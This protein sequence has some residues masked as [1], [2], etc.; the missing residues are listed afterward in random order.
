M[1]EPANPVRATKLSARSGWQTAWM[2]PFAA[3]A[4]YCTFK[5]PF[6]F[7]PRDRLYSASYAFGFNNSVA[8][9]SF[10]ILLGVASLLFARRVAAPVGNFQ[11]EKTICRPLRVAFVFMSVLYLLATAAMYRYQITSAPWLMWE[12]RHLSYRTLLMDVYHLHAYTD[13]SAEY[14]PLLTYAPFYLYQL[15]KPFRGTNEQAY[16]ICHLLL[17]LGGLG[18][19]VYLLSYVKLSSLSRIVIFVSLAISGFAPYMGINGV[20]LRY[21]LP[22]ASLLIAWRTTRWSIDSSPEKR[23]WVAVGAIIFL[24][25]SANL[26]ISS[27]I[28]LAFT[29]AWLSY[30]VFTF[31]IT[32][33]L[34]MVSLL[35]AALV[36]LACFFFLPAAYYLTLL[37]FSR[38]ANNFPLLP[39]PHLLLYLGTMFVIVP[40]LLGNVLRK[41]W[42]NSRS[43]ALGAALAVLCMAMAPGALGRCDPPHVLLYGMGATLLLMI[44]L[45]ATRPAALG[46]YAAGYFAVFVVWMQLVHL[47]VFYQIPPDA[48]LSKKGITDIFWKL[49]HS[50]ATEAPDEKV[51]SELDRYSHIGLP[52]ATLSDPALEHHIVLRGQLQ[53][54]Y[55]IANVGIYT[56]ADLHRKLNDLSK[57]RYILVP[58]GF[59]I[60]SPRHTCEDFRQ[61]MQRWFLS[62]PKL[63]CMASS[64]DPSAEINSFIADHFVVVQNIGSSVLMRRVD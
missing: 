1:S 36:L 58:A 61:E 13:F 24:L 39:A 22:F 11:I 46:L 2:I 15:L 52:F 17:N 54:E 31:R 63:P 28:G 27:E 9:L 51:L 26:L 50:A 44:R 43:D 32:P 60:H 56:S 48:W 40:A 62:S 45:G 29:L 4:W 34:L 25:L 7:P 59:G 42:D 12:V 64:L 49:D 47:Q 19:I 53:P 8:I 23:R 6:H 38:G 55:Y 16:F 41:P 35:A 57:M 20:L 14:G 18:C 37:H 5:L 10:L 21:L 3:L 30:C 33:Y